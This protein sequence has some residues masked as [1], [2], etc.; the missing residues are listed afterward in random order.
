MINAFR[1]GRSVYLAGPIWKDD[2]PR[3]WRERAAASLPKGWEA[4]DPLK[5]EVDYEKP[6]EI[7]KLDYGLIL[8]SQAII[9]NVC[10]PS[11]GTAMELAFAHANSRPVFAFGVR[12]DE[13]AT[14]SPWLRHHVTTL[15]FSLESAL[16]DLSSLT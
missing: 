11:W 10:R 2:D 1:P 7:V 9:A 15:R 3:S 8:K 4:L 16:L 12:P 6:D 14:Q 13:R 5:F